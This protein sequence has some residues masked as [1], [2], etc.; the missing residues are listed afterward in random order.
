LAPNRG[1]IFDRNGVLLAENV[2]NYQLEI[3]PEQVPDLAATLD[4]LGDI[5]DLRPA[6]IERFNKLRRTKRSF[7]PIPLRY[8]LTDEDVARFAVHRQDFPGVDIRAR[9]TRRYPLGPVAAHAIGYIG[10]INES[11]LEARDPARYSGTSQ[12]GKVGIEVAY[13]ESLHGYPGIE[14]VETNAQNRTL[15]TL[16]TEA[17][18]PGTDLYLS[19]DAGLQKAAYEALGE[20]KGAAVAI[21]P[22]NGEVLALVAKPAYD[23]NL[24]VDGID[25]R[26]F[27]RLNEDPRRPLFN[28]AVVGTYPPGSTI[29]PM[30]GLA[31]L[32]YGVVTSTHSTMC[33]GFFLLE[34]NPRP[35]RDWKREGHG[36]TDMD[37][38][39]AESCDV[40]YYELAVELGIDRIHEFLERFGLGHETGIDLIGE[41]DGLLPSREWKRRTRNMPWFPG[42]TVNVGIGQGF[43]LTTPLQ[44]AHSTARLAMRGKAFE[45]RLVH[46]MR[47]PES[48]EI[49]KTAVEPLPTME[50]RG[51]WAWEFITNSMERVLHDVKGTAWS[52]GRGLKYRMAGKTGTAQV[53]TLGEDEEYEEEEVAA[54]LRDHGLFIAYAPA[55]DPE[56]ALAVVVENGGGGSRAA[57][58]ARKIMDAWLLREREPESKTPEVATNE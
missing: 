20:F 57:P 1:L 14:Q 48:G 4:R 23:P 49:R 27:R 53:Y 33:R 35:Y 40:Y 11:E 22:N 2:P 12:I 39:I 44:L 10:S 50:I 26:N 56:L 19:I 17:P 28:R 29:K 34:G 31:G 30:L 13:E 54:N 58:V 25:S 6:D 3:I 24:F 7:Q 46:A 51:D 43:M 21:D 8:S 55:D 9:L 47:D 15:R 42:E 52:A 36:H 5:I 45:P 37:K 32:H 18:T 38:A 41:R 16:E